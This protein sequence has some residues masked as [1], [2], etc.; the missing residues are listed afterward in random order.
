ME[1]N[2]GLPLVHLS[3]VVRHK[4]VLRLI[5]QR[6]SYH[7][8]LLRIFSGNVTLGVFQCQR[9]SRGMVVDIT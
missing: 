9:W 4:E 5:T 3:W 6:Q 7:I 2:L 1:L 8:L